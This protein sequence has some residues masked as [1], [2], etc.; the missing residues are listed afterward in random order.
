ME[1]V[2]T[3]DNGFDVGGGGTQRAS[4]V[5]IA[6]PRSSQGFGISE[7]TEKS[8]ASAANAADH[9]IIDSSKGNSEY[10]PRV[11]FAMRQ[12]GNNLS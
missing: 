5:S 8:R 3:D 6:C 12:P 1:V 4:T 10:D 7:E 9:A 2:V 11:T